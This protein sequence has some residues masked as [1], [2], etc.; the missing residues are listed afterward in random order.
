MFFVSSSFD[1]HLGE[2]HNLN[3]VNIAAINMDVPMSLVSAHW[4]DI[5]KSYGG[6][7]LNFFEE[8]SD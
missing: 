5:A 1:R 4:S 7:M 8:S 2:S 6:S 3:I